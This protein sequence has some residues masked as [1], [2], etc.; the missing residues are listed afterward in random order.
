M[1]VIIY[2]YVYVYTYIC[3]S[4]CI[5][6]RVYQFDESAKVPSPS[7]RAMKQKKEI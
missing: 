2:I 7:M 5:Y 6:M 4:I 1:Y 3:I